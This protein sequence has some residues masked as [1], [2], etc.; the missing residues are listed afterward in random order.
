[1][2]HRIEKL[3]AKMESAKLD[4]FWVTAP[5]EDNGRQLSANRRYMSGFSGSL[6]NLL[7]T[8][9][10]AFIA[11]DFRYCEQAERE[12]PDYT[13]YKAVGPLKDWYVKLLQEAGLEG[14]RIGFQ[15]ADVNVAQYQAMTKAIKELPRDR[16]PK[17][18]SSPPFVEQL[19]AV[20]TTDEIAL[21]QKAVDIGDEAFVAISQLVEP[22]WTE[23]KVA[24]EI[25]RYAREHGAEALSFETIVA[26]GP[27]GAMPH[28]QPRDHALQK[29]DMIVIDMGVRYQGYCSDLTRTIFLGEPDDQFK[30]VYSIVLGAQLTAEELIETG[31]EGEAAH[32]I[33]HNVIDEA[34]YGEQFGHGLGHGVGLQIHELPR[35]AKTSK[36]SLA[37]GNIITVEPGIYIPGWGGVRIEDQAVMDNGRVRVLSHAPKLSFA[38]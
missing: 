7:I 19:R 6:G 13:L 3:R 8:R 14:K 30:T 27:S 25:E 2:K 33:A 23:R 32:M 17:L 37:D 1:M 20:K 24:W 9:D 5:A 36:D 16:Q 11:V 35:L 15:P 22:G 28:A 12:A 21:L 31:M 18:L 38:A 34:G 4:A 29:G 26:G 10:N